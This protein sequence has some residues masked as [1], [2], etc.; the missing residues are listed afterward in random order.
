[1]GLNKMY[2][3]ENKTKKG[4]KEFIGHYKMQMQRFTNIIPP[5]I[6]KN[7]KTALKKLSNLKPYI[8]T[9]STLNIVK[10]LVSDELTF[11]FFMTLQ[12]S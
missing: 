4:K 7:M 6:E 1:M 12:T 5:K 8:F 11:P 3:L 10:R 9:F 2:C